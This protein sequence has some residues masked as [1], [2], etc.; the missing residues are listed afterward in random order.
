MLLPNELS[1]LFKSS[2]SAFSVVAKR[3][4]QLKIVPQLGMIL[5]L[6]S[7]FW[8]EPPRQDT[9]VFALAD[10]PRTLDPRF[11]TDANGQRVSELLF[12]SLLKLDSDLNLT[13]DLASH[14]TYKNLEY[15][16]FIRPKVQ[17]HD[18]KHLKEKD[19]I[20]S[21]EE[22]RKESSLFAT[23]FQEIETLKVTY[24][25]ETGGT[26]H[27]KLR[28]FLPNFLIDLRMIKILPSE[29]IKKSPESFTNFPIGTGPFALTQ[30]NSH[31][32]KLRRNEGYF[33]DL[34][35]MKNVLFKV[36]K[37][38]NTRFL[39]MYKGQIDIVQ[40]D[41]PFTKVP[42]FK[43]KKDFKVITRPGLSTT[44]L[45]INNR[46]SLLKNKNFRTALYESID[47]DTVIKYAFEGNAD[48][49]STLIPPLLPES[50][51]T[52]IRPETPSLTKDEISNI[53]KGQKVSLK[54]SNNFQA[55]ENGQMI[56]AQLK[57]NGLD[58]QL[59]S[60]EWG[61][62]Y[63]DIKAGRFELAIMKWV[64]ILSPDIYRNTLHSR[65]FPPGRNRGYFENLQFDNLVDEAY[66]EADSLKRSLLYKKVQKIVFDEKPLIPLWHEKQVAIINKRVKNYVLP[67]DG[68]FSNLTKVFK[69]Y[70]QH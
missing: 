47:E 29:L 17:F 42:F 40:S 56:A 19:F 37:D 52:L 54:T 45:L 18:G 16:F 33:A 27:I 65:E 31:E 62:Y 4:V 43:E 66:G 63:G 67:L 41:I 49:A 70:E 53:F 8:N 9:L 28:K 35:K 60:F 68:S 24:N 36:I 48:P 58:V 39:K 55:L 26:L 2:L 20:F 44:Y 25:F 1:F 30:F 32:I 15:V 13:G 46:H 38:S 51:K 61:T 12:S 23:P 57:K 11:A 22:F 3:L 6:S 64:G 34:V 7:C 5:I 59:K 50:D 10:S 69:V 21:F 14:W